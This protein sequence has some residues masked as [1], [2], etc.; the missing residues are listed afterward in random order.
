L[1]R[2]KP[3]LVHSVVDEII[4]PQ[5]RVF[6]LLLQFLRVQIQTAVLLLDEIL[7]LHANCL[8]SILK[9]NGAA[10]ILVS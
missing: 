2:G 6:N 3:G 4:L 1:C 7:K 10:R 5:M 9:C 8:L